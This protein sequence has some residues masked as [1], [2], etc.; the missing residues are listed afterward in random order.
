MIDFEELFRE[1]IKN[2]FSTEIE[3]TAKQ[4]SE[5]KGL[6]HEESVEAIVN[7]ILLGDES[8]GFGLDLEAMK[9]HL[10]SFEDDDQYPEL[11][12][13]MRKQLDE[14]HREDCAR[15][16]I[17]LIIEDDADPDYEFDA[18]D[19]ENWGVAESKEILAIIADSLNLPYDLA[20]ARYNSRM[21][22]EGRK[23]LMYFRT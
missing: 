8:L 3:V 14:S 23:D 11:S 16:A 5:E 13:E 20:L 18:T 9:E 10:D 19:I 2:L 7:A 15:Q 12:D 4:W 21:E 22:K 1:N 17:C 6:T